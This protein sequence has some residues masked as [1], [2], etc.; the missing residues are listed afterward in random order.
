M[1]DLYNYDPVPVDSSPEPAQAVRAFLIKFKNAWGETAYIVL[2][3]DAWKAISEAE[4]ALS[5]RND[6]AEYPYRLV[7][8]RELEGTVVRTPGL[9]ILDAS[10]VNDG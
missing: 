9:Q 5:A 6:A 1:S 3:S 2:A 4:R 10:E 8:A 7:F